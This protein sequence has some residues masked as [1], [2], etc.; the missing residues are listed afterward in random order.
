MLSKDKLVNLY[1]GVL[2][3]FALA[4]IVWAIRGITAEHVDAG[5]V[6]VA[7]LAVFCSCYLPIRL[8]W[9]KTD[10]SISDGLIVLSLLLYGGEIAVLL[11][12]VVAALSAVIV[13]PR[14]KT[15]TPGTVLI[16]TNFAA[17]GFFLA[18]KAVTIMFGSV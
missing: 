8:P 1:I 5:M 18:A 11:A 2:S 14:T 3:V 16:K 9:V 7:L 13:L 15:L 10:L 4:A 17:I 12:V 6:T